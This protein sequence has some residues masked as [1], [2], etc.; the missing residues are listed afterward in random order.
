LIAGAIQY[1]HL[2]VKVTRGYA[3]SDNSGFPDD[4]A[5]EDWLYR[6]EQ[7]DDWEQR[8]AAGEH[9][10]GDAADTYRHRFHAAS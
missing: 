6:L 8:L 2:F 5:F 9:V 1:G 3:G 4:H 10:S 7:L